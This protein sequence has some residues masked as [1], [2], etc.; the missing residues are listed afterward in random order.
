MDELE[1][2]TLKIVINCVVYVTYRKQT[3]ENKETEIQ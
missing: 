2:H 1:K 3:T